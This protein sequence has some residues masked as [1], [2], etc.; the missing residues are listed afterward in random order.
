MCI[1]NTVELLIREV[2]NQLDHYRKN[3]NGLTWRAKVLLLVDAGVSM[4]KL[5]R[6]ANPDA[7]G[8]SAH[9]RLELYFTSHAGAIIHTREL[10]V[11]SGI[12]DYARRIR[13]L[14]VQDGYKIL[15]SASNDPESGI[16]LSPSQYLLIDPEA[17]RTAARRWHLANRIRRQ[18]QGGS[19]ARLLKYFQ[20]NVHQ[21]VTTEELAYVARAKE[22]GRRVRELRT[23]QGYAIATRFTGRPDLRMGE[24][25]LET[26]ERISEPHDRQIPFE[27]QKAVYERDANTCR[28]CGWDRQKWTRDD[29][30]ILEL[31][32][33][34]EHHRQGKNTADNLIVLCS[35]CH[36]EV[37]AGRLAVPP[38]IL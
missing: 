14:R 18:E 36:D 35:R 31:H 29:P 10:A 28:L 15:S 25:V 2:E 30:R 6:T 19:Q 37:H 34:E 24:Y 8:I 4:A 11:V 5:G 1:D 38:G 7:A 27:V 33:I 22:F 16:Q 12:S 3:H 13:E 20:K 21:V 32:H 9:D 17:D 23:E 26:L